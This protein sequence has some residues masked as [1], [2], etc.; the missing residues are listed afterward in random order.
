[1]NDTVTQLVILGSDNNTPG[2]RLGKD[3]ININ[4]NNYGETLDLSKGGKVSQHRGGND[5]SETMMRSSEGASLTLCSTSNPNSYQSTR[6]SNISTV[7]S[8][9]LGPNTTVPSGSA[10]VAPTTFNNMTI[11]PQS[12]TTTTG[13]TAIPISNI[14]QDN[15]LSL[16]SS[17]SHHIKLKG[18]PVE[19]K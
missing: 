1:M 19:G 10:I 6:L 8:G 9:T 2:K 4:T 11:F 3:S 17:I 14:S 18:K 7:K 5:N 12:Q 16:Q 15:A 13:S